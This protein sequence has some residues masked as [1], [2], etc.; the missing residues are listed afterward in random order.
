VNLR[1]PRG[2]ALVL[3]VCFVAFDVWWN[4]LWWDG[5]QTF[6]IVGV[7][8]PAIVVILCRLPP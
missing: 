8:V 6:G 5:W 1:R 4:I 7:A 3:S 2:W